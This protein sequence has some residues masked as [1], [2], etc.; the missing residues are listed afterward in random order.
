MLY[1]KGHCQEKEKDNPRNGRNICK[2]ISD[3]GLVARLHE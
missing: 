1:S 2:S 3:G